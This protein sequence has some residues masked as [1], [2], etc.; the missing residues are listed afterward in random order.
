MANV[1]FIKA[2]NCSAEDSVSVRMYDTFLASYKETHQD[3]EIVQTDLFSEHLPY[4]G[5]TMITGNYKVAN[6][7]SLTPEEEAEQAFV[8]KH[9]EPFL[10]AD[11]V[12]IAF[13]L[14]NL[15]VPAVLH[16]YLDYLHQPRKTFKYSD[17][18]L[19]GLL[20]GK[21]VALLNARGGTYRD[22][23]EI[24][25]NFVK[26]HLQVFGITDF[27]MVR[28]EGHRQAPGRSEE[29]IV[30]GLRATDQAARMF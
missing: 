25:V 29:I 28:I 12:V 2:N 24:A 10:A 16:T 8:R 30:D 27:T 26:K 17:A 14:W 7:Y 1:L 9:L 15:T 19:V 11:K 5:G 20:P 23:D 13:P 3:D 18:G 4:L 21:K 22:E 6:G